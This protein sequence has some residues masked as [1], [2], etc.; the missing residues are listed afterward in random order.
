MTRKNPRTTTDI[1]LLLEF[2]SHAGDFDQGKTVL[3]QSEW[4][5][6]PIS[7]VYIPVK[8]MMANA[9]GF[10]SLYSLRQVHF[11]EVYSDIIDRAFLGRLRGPVD[12][13][14]KKLLRILQESM[15]GSVVERKEEFFLKHSSGELEFTLLAE[16]L[17]KL[18]LIWLLIQNGVLANGSVIFWD[19]PEANLNPTLIKTVVN[20]L[21]ELRR[22]GVQVFVSTHNYFVL[23]EFD[24]QC[25]ET[26]KLS[27]HSLFREN[28]AANVS[29][30]AFANLADVRPNLIDDVFADI[31]DREM[32]SELDRSKE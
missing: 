26:D 31:I 19:E 23:K 24:M 13:D 2:T 29:H 17:R 12:K 5:Q 20:I 14:R 9:P 6:N 16:G 1:G 15:Q 11:E 27:Y 4:R 22:L 25:R 28:A 30:A 3:K 32:V 10:R 8:D 18:G 7:A 21:I